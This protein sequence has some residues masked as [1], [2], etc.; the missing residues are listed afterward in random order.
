MLDLITIGDSTIDNIVTID[1]AKIK[2]DLKKDERLLCFNYAEK[3]P[4]KHMV[5][6]VGGNATNIAVGCKK[7]GLNVAIVTELG[8]DVGG[9][10]IKHEMEI[11]KINTGLLKILKN[12]ETRYSVI[13]NYQGERTILSYY[14]ERSYTLP[15]LPKTKWIYYTSLGKSFENLQD[16][17]L[18]YLFANPETKLAFNPGSYQMKSGLDKIKKILPHVN[19]LF[20]N[21]QEA[22]KLV[23]K[24]RNT[25]AL[26][27]A[28]LKKGVGQVVMTDGVLGS[29]ATTGK[30]IYFMKSYPQKPKAKT[31]AGDA[32]SSGFLSAILYGK[33]VPEAMQWGTANATNV[34]MQIGAQKGL[35]NKKQISLTIKKYTKIKTMKI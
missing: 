7:L 32:Y 33:S 31:G 12:K 9:F 3:I 28:L 29:F 11:A 14:A 16:K 2:C 1:D 4:I 18:K 25:K 21:R 19:L 17:L 8:D 23:G 20:V 13:L 15:K 35:A 10:S 27:N 30:E 5:Q 24:K 34:I 6:S 26:I 22:E